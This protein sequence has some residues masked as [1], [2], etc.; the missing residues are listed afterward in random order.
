MIYD[1]QLSAS[2]AEGRAHNLALDSALAHL[3]VPMLLAWSPTSVPDAGTLRAIRVQAPHVQ[4]AARD[5]AALL[6]QIQTLL[7]EKATPRQLEVIT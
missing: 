2:D 1:P 3:D 5:P 6:G 4:L 7:V